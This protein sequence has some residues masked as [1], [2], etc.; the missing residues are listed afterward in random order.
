MKEN[1][2]NKQDEGGAGRQSFFTGFLVLLLVLIWGVGSAVAFN[3]PTGNDDLFIR[4]DNTIR[5][6]LQQRLH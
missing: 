4:W 5:Y 3:I 6:T 2:R 1:S